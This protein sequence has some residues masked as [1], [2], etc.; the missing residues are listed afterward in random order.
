MPRTHT[1][2]RV[3]AA[4]SDRL[5]AVPAAV[6]TTTKRI[7]ARERRTLP[8][9]GRALRSFQRT[10]QRHRPHLSHH[11]ESTS[12]PYPQESASLIVCNELRN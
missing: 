7:W 9:T 8:G 3:D 5:N 1:E 11:Y 10:V 12:S 4:Q 2:A 6:F